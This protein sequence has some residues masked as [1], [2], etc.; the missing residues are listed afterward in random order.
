M[1]TEAQTMLELADR[2]EQSILW[3]ECPGLGKARLHE[4]DQALIVIAL[5]AF[6]QSAPPFSAP[7]NTAER[8]PNGDTAQGGADALLP[9]QIISEPS[10]TNGGLVRFPSGREVLLSKKDATALRATAAIEWHCPKCGAGVDERFDCCEVHAATAAAQPVDERFDVLEPVEIDHDG[11]KGDVIGSYTTRE[12]K[13]GVVIQQQGTRVVHV[14][15]EKWVKRAPSPLP[16]PGE[17]AGGGEKEIRE[18]CAT[19]CDKYAEWAESKISGD[20]S[21]NSPTN[22][23]WAGHSNTANDLAEMIR[24]NLPPMQEA[25]NG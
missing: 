15:G 5:R 19:T 22:Q 13:R 8:V 1:T 20:E 16:A 11:F 25:S 4:K 7:Q 17:V 3:Q 10:K 21:P 23:M 14:Y 2:L 6:H 18:A 9:I 24:K 12:G